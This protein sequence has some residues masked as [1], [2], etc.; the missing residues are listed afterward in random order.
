MANQTVSVNRNLDDAAISGLANGEDIT[1]NTG[2]VLTIN[3]DSRYGQQAAVI[4]AIT[5]NSGTGGQCLIDGRDVWE[6]PFN[7]A[8]GNVPAL[9]TVGVYDC[10]GQNTFSEGEFLGIWVNRWEAPVAVGQPV[11]AAGILKLR[12]KSASFDALGEVINI[13]GGA[14]VT[15][16]GAG[17]AGWLSIVGEGFTSITVPRVGSFRAFGAWFDLGL[18]DGTDDQVISF[19]SL[20]MCPAI[21]IETAP[22]SGVYEQWLNAGYIRWGQA[23]N[24][25]GQDSRGKLFGQ[26]QRITGLAVTTGNATITGFSDTSQITIGSRAIHSNLGA[27]A[28]VIAKDATTVTLSV[29]NATA[30]S[31]LTINFINEKLYLARRSSN[32]CGYKPPTGCKIRVPNIHVS[33]ALSTVGAWARD[34]F[35]SSTIGDRWEFVT[36]SAGDIEMSIVSGNWY[37]NFA[38][39][40]RVVL[41]SCFT[42]D[43]I[44]ISEC[45]TKPVLTNCAVGLVGSVD[46]APLSLASCFQGADVLGGAYVKYESETGDLGAAASDVVGLNINGARF[47][48][49]GD[50]TAATLNRGAAGTACLTLTRC[51]NFTITSPIL[52]GASMRVMSCAEGDIY[53]P[54]YCDQIEGQS[55]VTTNGVSGVDINSG[56]QRIRVHGW[57]GNLDA[58][59][60]VHPYVSLVSITQ[61]YYCL[62]EDIG[63]PASPFNCGSA[64]ATGTLVLFNGSGLKSIARNLYGINLRTSVIADNN[65][66]VNHTYRNCWGDGADA[67]TINGLGADVRGLRSTN[68][69]T[70]ATSVYGTHFYDTFVS[71]TEP[72]LIFLANEPTLASASKCFVSA[73]VGLFTSTGQLKLVNVGD[74]VTWEMD[75]F[76][77][78]WLSF[79]NAAPTFSG[80][81]AANH[82]LEYQIERMINGIPSGWNGTWLTA[83][84]AN[85][86]AE[87]IPAYVSESNP[88][89]VRLKFRVRC[90]VAA[91]ANTVIN[92]RITGVTD[93]A[94]YVIAHPKAY[95]SVKY[96]GVEA[97]SILGVFDATGGLLNAANESSG[98]VEAKPAWNAN[99]N[100]TLRLRRAGWL[101][102]DTIVQVVEAGVSLPADQTDWTSVADTDPGALGITLTNHGATPVTWNGKDFSITV[103]TTDD[104]LT[105]AQVAAFISWNIARITVISGFS[106]LAWPTMVVPTTTGYETER[107]TLF[108][109]AGAAL[110]GVRVVRSDGTTAVIGFGRMQADD[111]TYWVAPE[112]LTISAP[113]ISAG[114]RVWLYNVTTDTVLEDVVLGSPGYSYV[115]VNGGTISAGDSIELRVARISYN[116]LTLTGASASSGL[117]FTNALSLDPVYTAI[118]INGAAVTGIVY[119]NDAVSAGIDALDLNRASDTIS[120]QEVYAWLSYF[121]ATSPGIARQPGYWSAVDQANFTTPDWLK[122]RNVKVAPTLATTVTDGYL[123][124]QTSSESWIASNWLQSVQGRGFLAGGEA[125]TQTLTYDGS[126]RIQFDSGISGTAFPIGTLAAP[127]DNFADALLIAQANG[128]H[129][130][131]LEQNEVGSTV[132]PILQAIEGYELRRA[133]GTTIVLVL[134][135]SYSIDRSTFQEVIL[136]GVANP[137]GEWAARTTRLLNI[138]GVA[139][140]FI[141]SQFSGTV[142]IRSSANGSTFSRC[143]TL[144]P[145]TLD[146]AGD[147]AITAVFSDF[148]GDLTVTNLVAGAT[149]IFDSPSA[150]ITLAASCTGGTV[151]VRGD[152]SVT[153][154]GAATVQHYNDSSHAIIDKSIDGTTD[155]TLIDAQRIMLAFIA[156]KLNIEDL[157]GGDFRYSYRNPADTKTRL[158]GVVRDSDGDRTSVTTLDPT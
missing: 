134:S 114:A 112:T 78:G 152:A 87:T 68:P 110:K 106:G 34:V 33:S 35:P 141:E 65:S 37:L 81:N 151:V 53:S 84:A 104:G 129:T 57:G 39:P 92:V 58:L 157:G 16:T 64:N 102:S 98:V 75:Y 122:M 19:Y 72:R 7:A 28:Y 43:R 67:L 101:P 153:N 4:G 100:A 42:C 54:I 20:D 14:T 135:A 5:I 120:L 40:Y 136:T 62:V 142:G 80:T 44:L 121:S 48:T 15:A 154:N 103:T 29:N 131:M 139:G 51:T 47:I 10:T 2:A 156:G 26:G 66:E 99:Y 94:T 111:G 119:T 30:G 155:L 149:L 31:G 76:L 79:A 97:G 148:V 158:V 63:T 50:S 137:T 25:V 107:G 18:T 6:I 77:R 69:T 93:A 8:S 73:G 105:A 89:G 55:T 70:G 118:G 1:I 13:P 138:S 83:N 52:I 130:L 150:H 126:V 12:R 124:S 27:N 109:S 117:T 145:A 38:Q 116:R 56:S 125:L 17:K 95:P 60:N 24:R 108:G 86:F 9:G 90:T 11:P 88:G 45:A 32:A 91:E 3:S 82:V 22:G 46:T 123:Q 113:N 144:G 115:T 147:G 128:I 127:V 49:F 21:E 71:T 36:T 61:S 59:A 74:E 132:V 140:V 96:T 23:A 41:T 146:C 85:L 133:A 143:A